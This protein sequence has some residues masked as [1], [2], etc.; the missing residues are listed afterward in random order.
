MFKFARKTMMDKHLG[1]KFRFEGV[2]FS[3]EAE[4]REEAEKLV[5]EWMAAYFKEKK[6][7]LNK[8]EEI[9]FESVN[10]ERL[11]RKK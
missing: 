1:D 9:P 8:P 5:A 2:E 10:K 7:E 11:I 4:T 6:A 3:A